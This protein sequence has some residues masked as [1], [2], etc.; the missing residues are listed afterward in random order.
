MTHCQAVC[1]WAVSCQDTVWDFDE[2][3][4]YASCVAQLNEADG[5]CENDP[6]S[7]QL[8]KE[9]GTAIDEVAKT[10]VCGPFTGTADE[11]AAGA[12]LLPEVCAPFGSGYLSM[13]ASLT[14]KPD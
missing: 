14:A 12:D 5:D 4:L 2:E 9:C 10:G 11:Q 1:A 8:T 3:E 7:A 13:A 6:F